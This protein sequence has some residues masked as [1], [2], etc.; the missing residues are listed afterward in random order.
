MVK[1]KRNVPKRK[2]RKRKFGSVLERVLGFEPDEEMK[3]ALMAPIGAA[4]EETKGFEDKLEEATS[5]LGD[6][7]EAVKTAANSIKTALEK[8]MKAGKTELTGTKAAINQTGEEGATAFYK[9]IDASGIKDKM[10]GV[11]DKAKAKITEKAQTMF[12]QAGKKNPLV[13]AS[14][15][16]AKVFFQKFMGKI[17]PE[18]IGKE[19]H[20]KYSKTTDMSK[21]IFFHILSKISF[22]GFQ[23]NTEKLLE[24]AGGAAAAAGQAAIEAAKKKAA[25]KKAAATTTA[26]TTTATTPPTKPVTGFGKRKRGP[27]ASLKR[28]CKKHGVRLMV[29]RGKKR[30]YK[31]SKV[32]KGECQ[33]KLKR[34][35]KKNFGR[36]KIKRSG[37][38]PPKRKTRGKK[39]RTIRKRLSSAA[40]GAKRRVSAA[41]R[42]AR[43]NPG[44]AAL[45]GLAGLGTLGLGA[46]EGYAKYKRSQGDESYYSP[47]GEA[48]KRVKGGAADVYVYFK[49]TPI[50]TIK[51]HI[52]ALPEKTKAKV[53]S[54]AEAAKKG[55]TSRT[56]I[57]DRFFP[58]TQGAENRRTAKL[59]DELPQG[60]FYGKR[61]RRRRR[62]FGDN[63]STHKKPAYGK[64]RKRKSSFGKKAKKPSA[65][66]KRMCKKL[67]VRMTLK[68][69]GKRVYKSE[70]MLKKQC[71]K[72]MKRKSKK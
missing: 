34:K 9:M 19:I 1:R 69:G 56:G 52:M 49:D 55:V 72:A 48:F 66:T 39:R 63:C 42:Y 20:T 5:K 15:P 53:I 40:R 67:K 54:A 57:F 62:K 23:E 26:T 45:G 46:Y 25:E 61:R 35:L 33:R 7:K 50:E 47:T 11:I 29:K 21:K 10:G 64:R 24:E 28:M 58:N 31:S 12:E 51:E 18:Y 6:K 27:S 17:T 13:K 59:L 16:Q 37:I 44:T 70:A 60:E 3:K 71:K 22:T 4:L 38:M 65:A 14:I 32:L 36:K 41:A 30:V 68:R 43:R 2:R 8:D